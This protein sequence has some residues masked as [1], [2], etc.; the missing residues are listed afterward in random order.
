MTP[1]ASESFT[2]AWVLVQ[3]HLSLSPLFG[4]KACYL[5][6]GPPGPTHTSNGCAAHPVRN[7]GAE[8]KTVLTYLLGQLLTGERRESRGSA[9]HKP[10]V[11][12]LPGRA[13]P[14]AHLPLS[15]S[16]LCAMVL[17]RAA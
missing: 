4:H 17:F 3:C 11:P 12:A 13:V 16:P 14:G 15:M 6:P 2:G 1:V 10:L 9:G 7:H 8:V 5:L